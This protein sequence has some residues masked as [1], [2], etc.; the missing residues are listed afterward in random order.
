MLNYPKAIEY[1]QK[2]LTLAPGDAESQNM[3]NV[4]YGITGKNGK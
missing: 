4:L 2:A 3:L 1:L